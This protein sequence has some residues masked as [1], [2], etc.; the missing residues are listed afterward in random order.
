[1][2]GWPLVAY[3]TK[4]LGELLAMTPPANHA[5]GTFAPPIGG[6]LLFGLGVLVLAE[7]FAHGLRLRE[8]VDATV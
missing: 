5:G 4:V 3:L 7:V 2:L 1:M 6:A 8:D